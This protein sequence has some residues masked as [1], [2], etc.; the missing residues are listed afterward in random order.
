MKVCVAACHYI[1]IYCY[2]LSDKVCQKSSKQTRSVQRNE[3]TSYSKYEAG[4][5]FR[6]IFLKRD[7]KTRIEDAVLTQTQTQTQ[8][9]THQHKGQNTR[10]CC[11]L[12]EGLGGS[13]DLP[14]GQD[15]FELEGKAQALSAAQGTLVK[16]TFW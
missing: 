11:V 16:N 15:L 2:S 13:R 10:R 9:Q 5:I 12:C 4:L 7:E 1:D 3:L 8:T 6:K 14:Q